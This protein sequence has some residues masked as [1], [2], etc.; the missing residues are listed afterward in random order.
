[1][2]LA[3]QEFEHCPRC[4]IE[5]SV[6]CQVSKTPDGFC[7]RCA[8]DIDGTI[9]ITADYGELV[10]PEKEKEWKGQQEFNDLMN[11]LTNW[12]DGYI[13]I[14]MRETIDWS[15][16]HEFLQEFAEQ[17]VPYIARL[18]ET[19]YATQE[20]MRA[21]GETVENC[22]CNIIQVLEAEEGLL[23]RSLQ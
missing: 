1:M 3:I 12:S 5:I 20:R 22:L 11:M 19:G 7:P 17:M 21:I 9:D 23:R 6:R 13:K 14:I 10:D 16:P 2:A 18:R 8:Y 15:L 4:G